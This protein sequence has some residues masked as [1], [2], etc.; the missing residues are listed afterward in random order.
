MNSPSRFSQSTKPYIDKSTIALFPLSFDGQSVVHRGLRPRENRVPASRQAT[1]VCRAVADRPAAQPTHKMRPY[2]Y[3]RFCGLSSGEHRSSEFH[4]SVYAARMVVH[5]STR[6]KNKV[7][8]LAA[9]RESALEI[10]GASAQNDWPRSE[11]RQDWLSCKPSQPR[12]RCFSCGRPRIQKRMQ[13]DSSISG[14]WEK[15]QKEKLD[16][17]NS[18][19]SGAARRR[20]GHR[21]AF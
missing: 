19:Q 15:H 3:E 2:R 8:S 10:F 14:M 13:R 12:C 11:S 21:L 7:D 16:E 20:R 18:I 1:K 5:S 17:S 6:K 9:R 4:A